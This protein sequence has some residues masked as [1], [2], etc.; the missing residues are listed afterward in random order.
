M[1]SIYHENS[2]KISNLC[3]I[4]ILDENARSK[5]L[6]GAYRSRGLEDAIRVAQQALTLI[7]PDN[8][9]TDP[10]LARLREQWLQLTESLEGPQSELMNKLVMIYLNDEL[11]SSSPLTSDGSAETFVGGAVPE[12]TVEHVLP[13]YQDVVLEGDETIRN[14]E[15]DVQAQNIHENAEEVEEEGEVMEE[16]LKQGQVQGAGGSAAMAT[17]EVEPLWKRYRDAKQRVDVQFK[18]SLDET[19]RG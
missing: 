2:S 18:Q 10:F 11:V 3:A 14:T 9:L 17:Q 7:S 13:P 4:Q 8:V 1:W 19:L 15:R 6:N 16:V 12:P 5:V